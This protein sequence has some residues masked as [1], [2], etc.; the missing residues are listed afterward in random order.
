MIA[1][2]GAYIG[3]GAAGAIGRSGYNGLQKLVAHGVS[4][5]VITQATGGS[6]KHGFLS[7]AISS[8]TPSIKSSVALDVAL[9]AASGGIAAELS[10][11]KF[12]TGAFTASIVR[13]FNHNHQELELKANEM[14]DALTPY[15][16][17]GD[18]EGFWK[19]A[20]QYGDPLADL[21]LEFHGSLYGDTPGTRYAIGRL[22]LWSTGS[23]YRLSP[24][25]LLALKNRVGID[26]LRRHLTAI[27]GDIAGR[28]GKIG[29]L[30]VDQVDRYHID[31]FK[32]IGIPGAYGAQLAISFGYSDAKRA[33]MYCPQCDPVSPYN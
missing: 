8:S 4:Q 24:S 23:N 22:E 12:A 10:G 19:T 17:S 25:D 28:Y 30:S 3:I 7:A 5:G 20:K 14:V 13:L 26:L 15:A 29:I 27:R 16:E 9:A 31:Y 1:G 6:F 18:I 21:A 11:G 33:E 32:R 2:A